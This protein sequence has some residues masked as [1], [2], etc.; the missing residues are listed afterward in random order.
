MARRLGKCSVSYL[1]GLTHSSRYAGRITRDPPTP[2]AFPQAVGR[3]VAWSIPVQSELDHWV[4]TIK[5]AR[6]YG[7]ERAF[8]RDTTVPGRAYTPRA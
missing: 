1:L 7:S 8:E 3:R 5:N 4:P 2:I 6:S